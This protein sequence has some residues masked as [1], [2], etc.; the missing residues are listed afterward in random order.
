MRLP[1]GDRVKGLHRVDVL[2]CGTCQ[3]QGSFTP[4]RRG[5]IS[6]PERDDI[7]GLHPESLPRQKRGRHPLPPLLLL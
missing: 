7:V 1:D 5:P 3:T 4:L 6:E 2:I